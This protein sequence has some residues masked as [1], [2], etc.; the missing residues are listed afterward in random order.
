MR[1]LTRWVPLMR[2]SRQVDFMCPQEGHGKPDSW[3][4]LAGMGWA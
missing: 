4:A 1:E 3:L 2:E